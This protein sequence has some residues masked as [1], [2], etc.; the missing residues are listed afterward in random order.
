MRRF[1]GSEHRS[2]PAAGE[3][4]RVVMASAVGTVFEWY[5]F[6]LFATLGPVLAAQFFGKLRPEAAWL[7]SMLAFAAAFVVRP[8]GALLF[9]RIGDIAGRKYTFLI[10]IVVMGLSTFMVGVLPNFAAIGIAAPIML[11]GLRMLQG[12]AMGGEYGGAAVYV[13]EYAQRESRGASTAWIQL[14]ASLGLLLALLVVMG[15]R[16]VLGE[17]EFEAWGWRVPFLISAVLLAVSMFIRWGLRES[18]VFER[19]R[20]QGRI[21]R[22]PV[23]EAFGQW[24]HLRL[25][26]IA[27]FGL[28]AGQAVVWY[29]GQVYVLMFLTDTL[30]VDQDLATL[31]VAAALCLG[32]PFFIA[33]GALSDRVGRKRVVLTGCLLASL[34]YFPVF[35]WLT[36]AANPA[37][38][39]A[40]VEAPVKVVGDVNTCS[41]P[42]SQPT[43]RPG[44]SDCDRVR[45]LLSQWGVSHRFEYVHVG[46]PVA[47]VVEGQGTTVL[48]DPSPIGPRA[49]AD[50]AQALEARLRD[51]LL[52]A[53][54]P[55]GA[56]RA[57]VAV[58]KTILLLTY[59]VVLVA[60]VYGPMAAILA[61]MFPTRIRYTAMSVPYHIGNGWFGGLLPGIAAAAAA[62]S[63]NIYAGL[64]YP[65]MVAGATFLIGAWLLPET[66]GRDM[67]GDG[68]TA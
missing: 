60:M 42:F 9:G 62:Q 67:G 23:R 46:S 28:T 50:R 11:I 45:Q 31:L 18:P 20:M 37:L 2:V 57:N 55:L 39:R 16:K 25:V 10:T 47:L 12:L 8:V 49:D 59:L 29:G 27:L 21:S 63:G 41:S 36:E 22:R 43:Q 19:A 24:R 58:G 13:A 40:M 54:Y 33:F 6:Y 26:L 48:V 61:E 30:R 44:V 51:A 32:A 17:S 1:A 15:V 14:T 7:F 38:A 64:W 68:G 35:G 4:R 3:I 66:R 65:V 34:S 53:D 52:R 56:D 5:D